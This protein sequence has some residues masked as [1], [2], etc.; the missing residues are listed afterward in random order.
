MFNY[1]E[2]DQISAAL[3][4]ARQMLLVDL[5]I[6]SVEGKYRNRVLSDLQE[7]EQL[8]AKVNVMSGTF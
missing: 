1:K 2:L 4:T 8:M 5:E 3:D 7:V 6:E